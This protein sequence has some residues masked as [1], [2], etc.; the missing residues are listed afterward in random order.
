MYLNYT[1]NDVGP[2]LL[3]YFN[4]MTCTP[5]AIVLGRVWALGNV[6][7]GQPGTG[8]GGILAL[9]RYGLKLAN[10]SGP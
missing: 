6:S 3:S 10:V 8:E 5:G 4:V 7:A 1:D 9:A 2:C